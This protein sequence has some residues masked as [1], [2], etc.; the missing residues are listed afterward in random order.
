VK[1]KPSHLTGGITMNL[2][3]ARSE[4]ISERLL[5]SETRAKKSQRRWNRLRLSSRGPPGAGNAF[6]PCPR[7][8]EP[9]DYNMTINIGDWSFEGRFSYTSKLQGRS[10]VCIILDRTDAHA[11]LTKRCTY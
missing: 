7:T 2:A 4:T 11:L 10:V 3:R 5:D 8:I 9:W 6:R 1:S